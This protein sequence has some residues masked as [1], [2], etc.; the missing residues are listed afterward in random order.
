[1]KFLKYI[2]IIIEYLQILLFLVFLR[3]NQGETSINYQRLLQGH[4]PF[5]GKIVIMNTIL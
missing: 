3:T 5:L 1:M 4:F 2:D